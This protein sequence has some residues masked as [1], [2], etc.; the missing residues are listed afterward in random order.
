[1]GTPGWTGITSRITSTAAA[2]KTVEVA[3]T[4]NA[5]VT[6]TVIMAAAQNNAVLVL[7]VDDTYSW[8]AD[9]SNISG[10]VVSA[11]F[12]VNSAEVTRTSV[13][14]TPGLSSVAET[15]TNS[16]KLERIPFEIQPKLNS[17]LGA[18][19]VNKFAN[20]YKV[21]AATGALK[22]AGA[23]KMGADG[24]AELPIDKNASYI[25][26]IDS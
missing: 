1:M 12:T 17:N 26:A 5:V 22:F 23:A 24:K 9:D 20:L 8:Q 16:F 6:S 13:N 11:S 19:N 2:D 14:S 15:N 18:A 21:D 10:A 4:E 25:V 7:N 3:R